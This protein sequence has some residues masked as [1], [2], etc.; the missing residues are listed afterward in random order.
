[1]AQL[2][3][4]LVDDE[5]RGLNTMEKLLELNSP[6]VDIVGR[7]SNAD[8][9]IEKILE[10]KPDLVFLDIAMPVKSGFDLLR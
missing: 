1:M 2:R 5:P 9:A 6:E 7:C 8:Q 4:I 3:T 10:L